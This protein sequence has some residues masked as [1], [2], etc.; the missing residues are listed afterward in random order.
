M[1]KG[2]RRKGKN[3]PFKSTRKEK[4]PRLAFNNLSYIFGFLLSHTQSERQSNEEA[5]WENLFIGGGGGR[6]AGGR[7]NNKFSY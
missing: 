6:R 7:K 3:L 5:T 2:G 4:H 1:S